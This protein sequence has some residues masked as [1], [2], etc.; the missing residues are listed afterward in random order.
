MDTEAELRGHETKTFTILQVPSSHLN[1]LLST[2]W[3]LFYCDACVCLPVVFPV[4]LNHETGGI[5]RLYSIKYAQAGQQSGY[6]GV[7]L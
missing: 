4:E 2:Q 3:S 1:I 5:W 7:M 6:S